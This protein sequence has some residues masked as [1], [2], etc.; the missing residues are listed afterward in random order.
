MIELCL[1]HSLIIQRLM[2]KV[3][4][5]MNKNVL[6]AFEETLSFLVVSISS[7]LR[8]ECWSSNAADDLRR[9]INVH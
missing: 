5:F 4:L 8:V 9:Q 2:E 6:F 7:S 1:R 3:E